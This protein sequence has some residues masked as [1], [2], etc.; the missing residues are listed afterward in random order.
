VPASSGAAFGTFVAAGDSC[1]SGFTAVALK[2]DLTAAYECVGCTC[3]PNDTRCE[4]GVYGHGSYACP[5]YQYSGLLYNVFSNSCDPLPSDTKVHYFDVT[6]F[7]TCTPQG[8]GTPAT[9]SW[10]ETRIFCQ[11]DRVGA[12]CGAGSVCVPALS[13]AACTMIEGTASCD[14]TYPTDS[15]HTWYTGYTDDRTCTCSCAF[16]SANCA[17]AYIQAYSAANCA[18]STTV[19]GNGT[20]GDSCSLPFAPVSGKVIGTPTSPSCSPQG[21][22]GALTPTDPRKVCCR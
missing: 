6:G 17:G 16:G 1:P 10:A 14:A 9:P 4:S 3:V 13:A 7:T 22:N 5:S 8:T 21:P 12:G 11:A 2:R 18:G 20:Q 19:L 15:G